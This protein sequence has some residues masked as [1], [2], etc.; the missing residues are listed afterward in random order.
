MKTLA[1]LTGP[2]ATMRLLAAEHPDLPAP[3]IDVTPIYPNVLTLSLHHSLGDFEAWREALGIT[4]DSVERKI[5]GAG[6]TAMLEA[7]TLFAGATVELVG[8]GPNFPVAAPELT[9]VAA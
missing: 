2:L 5:L 6:T 4:P 8:H 3:H 1:D 7:R 9:A